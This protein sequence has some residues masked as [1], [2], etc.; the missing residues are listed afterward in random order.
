MMMADPS[1]RRDE[2][3]NQKVSASFIFN[4]DDD[5]TIKRNETNLLQHPTFEKED[6]SLVYYNNKN[7]TTALNISHGMNYF[8][9]ST[10]KPTDLR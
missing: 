1:Q 7:D 4:D 10:D 3:Q 2:S 9:K 8:R 6:G 5:K